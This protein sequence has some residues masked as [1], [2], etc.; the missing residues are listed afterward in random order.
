MTP[1]PGFAT[2]IFSR[3]L[4]S[5]AATSMANFAAC[6]YFSE[7]SGERNSVSP[8]VVEAFAAGAIGGQRAGEVHLDVEQVAKVAAY[9]SRFSRR[10]GDVPGI[11]AGR[12][13]RFAHRRRSPSDNC[14]RCVD[15]R[16]GHALRRHLSVANA[17]C[18]FVPTL[19]FRWNRIGEASCWIAKPP[20][21][22]APWWQ[23]WQ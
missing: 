18:H 12:R 20:A 21:G 3:D 14:S 17:E 16:R 23:A 11:G 19:G 8:G 7:S 2:R 22:D 1:L 5:L 9:S 15:R 6:I 4:Y 13:R 10:I